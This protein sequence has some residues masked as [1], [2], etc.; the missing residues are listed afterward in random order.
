MEVSREQAESGIKLLE[1]K[2]KDACE[3]LDPEL[4]TEFTAPHMG[5]KLNDINTAKDQYRTAIRGF[6]DKF[7]NIL[8]ESEVNQWQ[9]DMKSLLSFVRNH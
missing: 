4:I 7:K 8:T 2:V 3:D 1:N 6:L 9:A 5:A